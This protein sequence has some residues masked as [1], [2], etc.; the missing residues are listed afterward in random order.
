M[1]RGRRGG[2]VVV[3]VRGGNGQLVLHVRDHGEHDT[4]DGKKQNWTGRRRSPRCRCAFPNKQDFHLDV[5]RETL[6]REKPYSQVPA[7]TH[8]SP[9]SASPPSPHSTSRHVPRSRRTTPV[10]RATRSSGD[11]K[12]TA[13]EP[14][15]VIVL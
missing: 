12:G 14:A 1:K 13:Q 4:K 5:F 10:E 11:E 7:A 8:P 15:E 3:G 2:G 9:P 6:L